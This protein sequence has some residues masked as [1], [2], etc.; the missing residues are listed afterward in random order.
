MQDFL[1]IEEAPMEYGAETTQD[2]IERRYERWTPARFTDPA[3]A[4]SYFGPN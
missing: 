4:G 1:G 2:R 3:L